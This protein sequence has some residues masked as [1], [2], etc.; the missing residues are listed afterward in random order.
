MLCKDFY[1]EGCVKYV[2]RLGR[3]IGYPTANVEIDP[4]ITPIKK[5]VYS[6]VV[7]IGEK[8][9]KGLTNIGT[10]PTAGLFKKPLSE[11]YIIGFDGNLYNKKLR[12]SLK[13]FIR[14]EKKFDNMEELKKVIAENVRML[15]NE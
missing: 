11:T 5:G 10:A 6:S 4:A 2:Y 15:V 12:I 8:E 1:F 9:Y 13:D 7:T 3:T 14:E